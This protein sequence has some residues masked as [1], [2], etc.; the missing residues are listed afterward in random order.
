M[1]AGLS[2]KSIYSYDLSIPK[3]TFP[4]RL[5]TLHLVLRLS[6]LVAGRKSS[7]LVSGKWDWE[8][9]KTRS[10]FKVKSCTSPVCACLDH[11]TR[12]GQEEDRDTFYNGSTTR[13]ERDAEVRCVMSQSVGTCNGMVHPG[14]PN[15]NRSGD[16]HMEILREHLV[17]KS[18]FWSFSTDT[19]K[20]LT[21]EILPCKIQVL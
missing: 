6:S 2:L 13:T 4:A 16:T 5:I 20:R 9:C 21:R 19:C 11:I 14:I 8:Y 15:M 1:T 7:T 18:I 10:S 3:A 12:A 17:G